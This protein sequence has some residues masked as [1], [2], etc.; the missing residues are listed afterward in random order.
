M[1]S[2]SVVVAAAVVIAV[3]IVVDAA[4]FV[5]VLHT[6]RTEPR[7]CSRRASCS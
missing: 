7:A 3:V 4:A 1:A 2:V 6:G 5:F